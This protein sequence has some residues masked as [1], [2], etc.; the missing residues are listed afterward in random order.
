MRDW[1]PADGQ[2]V[3]DLTLKTARPVGN[4]EQTLSSGNR[5]KY[6]GLFTATPTL[7]PDPRW[8]F[9]LET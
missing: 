1:S 8:D 9:H 6:E 5:A 4:R 7:S 3:H 2:V